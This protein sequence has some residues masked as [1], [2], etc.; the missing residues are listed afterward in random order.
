VYAA[1]VD[2][3]E[4]L[5]YRIVDACQTISNYPGVSELMLPRTMGRAEAC[6][7]FHGEHSSIYYKCTLSAVA[8]RLFSEKMLMRKLFLF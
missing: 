7:E 3:E 1:S 8:P 2:N 4:G 5:C 6:I